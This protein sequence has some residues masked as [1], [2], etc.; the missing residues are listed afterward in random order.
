MTTAKGRRE[1]ARWSKGKPCRCGMEQWVA[2][3][4]IHRT[5]RNSGIWN[6]GTYKGFHQNGQGKDIFGI[7]A[8]RS[9]WRTPV[10]RLEVSLGIE[11]WV[12]CTGG[13]APPTSWDPL[14]QTSTSWKSSSLL[15]EIADSKE[16]SAEVVIEARVLWSCQ[17][18]SGASVSSN[19]TFVTAASISKSRSV[20][21]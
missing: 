8:L 17:Q 15:S 10:A 3:E 16:R 1:T 2:W 4:P 13:L 6:Q 18:N 9:Q 19:I 21:Q 11:R 12:G 5:V 14:C 20:R 7:T